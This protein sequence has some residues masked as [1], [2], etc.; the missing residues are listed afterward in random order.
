MVPLRVVVADDDAL[1]REGLVHVLEHAGESVVGTAGDAD[2]LMEQV[3]AHLPD[4]VITDIQMPPDHNEDGFRSALSLRVTHP[5]IAVIV[6]SQFLD[7]DYAVRLM[8]TGARGVGYLLKEKI[9]DVRTLNDAV[10][11]VAAGESVLD[12]D[13]IAMLVGRRT[14]VDSLLDA[15]TPREREVLALMA[16]GRSNSGIAADLVVTVPAVERHV[17]NIF[18]KLGLH[19]DSGLEHRRVRAVLT[20]LRS[21]PRHGDSGAGRRLLRS[22]P[23]VLR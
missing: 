18:A 12:P 3:N 15:L 23:L 21:G 10:R 2:E 5:Q 4:V 7:D 6:L 17:T 14:R 11:R 20:Y 8:E 9:G 1:I 16:Q 19:Q 22:V 13:V